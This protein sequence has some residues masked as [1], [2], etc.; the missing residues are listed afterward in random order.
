MSRILL[1]IVFVWIL[2]VLLK[3]FFAFIQS[4]Q[5][6]SNKSVLADNMVACHRCGLHVPENEAVMIDG[7]AYCNHPDCHQINNGRSES[8]LS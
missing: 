8:N 5:T 6:P 1:L 3:R 2:Y 7:N 4:N